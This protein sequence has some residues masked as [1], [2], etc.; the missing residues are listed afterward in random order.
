MIILLLIIII[1]II[2]IIIL[3]IIVIKTNTPAS[4]P[5]HSEFI[6]KIHIQDSYPGLVYRFRM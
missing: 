1:M 5:N 4:N 3:I 2:I 6:F